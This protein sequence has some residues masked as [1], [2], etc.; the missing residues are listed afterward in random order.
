M[1]ALNALPRLEP[2]GLD[3]FVAGPGPRALLVAG[4]PKHRP[5]TVDVA[6]VLREL[7]KQHPTL[8]VAAMADS[9]ELRERLG[10]RI[11]PSLVLIQGGSVREV[12]PGIKDWSVYTERL[13]ALMGGR[14]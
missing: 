12:I 1:S 13:D 9:P 11:D 5:E 10:L 4:D 6:V 7:V 3:G 2:G 14:S 8:T